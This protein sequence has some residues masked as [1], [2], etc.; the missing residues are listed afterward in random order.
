MEEEINLSKEEEQKVS[1]IV[2]ALQDHVFQGLDSKKKD[3][4]DNCTDYSDSNWSYTIS[5]DLS[6]L[7]NCK[8][9]YNPDNNQSSCDNMSYGKNNM[10][11]KRNLY[12]PFN[13]EKYLSD[14]PEHHKVVKDLCSNCRNKVVVE[15][16][17]RRL[18]DNWKQKEKDVR[19]KERIER[20]AQ[21]IQACLDETKEVA[22][23]CGVSVNTVLAIELKDAL[24]ALSK[25]KQDF[26]KHVDNNAKDWED[27]EE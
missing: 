1:E 24:Y 14:S 21:H 7:A 8:Y 2:D 3:L 12:Y 9:E 23:K 16:I 5:K 13:E 22:E 17:M 20:R 6:I 27:W 10:D 25:E 15:A 26:S 11:A 18:L 4:M 19:R